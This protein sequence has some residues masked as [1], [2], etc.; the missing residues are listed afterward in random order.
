MK[1][2][3]AKPDDAHGVAV[4]HRRA[5]HE[6]AAEAYDDE[7]LETW[8]P[9]ADDE[10]VEA[11]A[12][13]LDR[14]EDDESVAFVAVDDRVLGFADVA[15]DEEYLRAVYVDP[16]MSRRGLGRA[17]L[18]QAEWAATQAGAERLTV[19][20]SLNSVEFYEKNGYERLD[21]GTHE[22]SDGHEITCVHM[23]KEFPGG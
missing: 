6:L 11:W 18:R 4:V 16:E 1:V 13:K 2:R 21:E 8:S 12:D 22:L 10:R 20:A 7:V 19:D 15:P 3:R 14:D 9:P 17:L 23:F 5:V